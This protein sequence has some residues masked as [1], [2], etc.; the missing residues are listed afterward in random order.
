ME[1]QINLADV[2]VGRLDVADAEQAQFLRQPALQGA[3]HALAA[4]ARLRR[5]GR[6][7]LNAQ[8][9]QCPAHL[10]QPF[11]VD[12]LAGRR[13]EEIMAAA[14]GVEARWQAPGGEHF[15]KRTKRRNGPFLLDQ[16]RR[17]NLA[18]GVIH[19][20]HEIKVRSPFKP[21]KP[22][23]G[24]RPDA[25]SCRRTACAVVC[26]DAGRADRTGPQARLHAA[27][28]W[29]RCSPTQSY[30]A[31]ANARGNASRSSPY[32]GSGTDPASR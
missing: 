7:M 26:A 2:A 8:P 18:G 17:V 32:G 4:A 31:A 6:D 25:A 16:K 24:W 21:P 5:V 10:G 22:A 28:S 1:R 9:C 30:V 13:G 14:V 3:E 12:R 15:E 19:R 23:G 27:A 29:S 20:H 11:F